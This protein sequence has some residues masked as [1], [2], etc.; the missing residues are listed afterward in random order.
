MHKNLSKG[1]VNFFN[2]KSGRA[3]A[4]PNGPTTCASDGNCMMSI[5]ASCCFMTTHNTGLVFN[6]HSFS[7]DF[8]TVFGP[9]VWL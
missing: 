1:G 6:G 9:P 2:V 3:K 5:G 4:L 7:T 8:I